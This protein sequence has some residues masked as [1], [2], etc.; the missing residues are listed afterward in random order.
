MLLGAIFMMLWNCVKIKIHRV[1]YRGH[2]SRLFTLCFT[3]DNERW[4]EALMVTLML[5]MSMSLHNV[6]CNFS[7]APISS[8]G[9]LPPQLFYGPFS[10]TTQVSRCQKRKFW[11]LWRKGRLTEAD[12]PT[13]QLGTTPSRLTSAHL[14][15]PPFFTGRMSFLPYMKKRSPK[16]KKR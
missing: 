1:G 5:S 10:G 9:I 13:I 6:A 3:N 7:M 11:T 8:I 12:T 16:I 14:H 2:Y 15:H 4:Y